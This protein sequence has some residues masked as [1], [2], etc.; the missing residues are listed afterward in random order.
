MNECYT[1]TDI[2]NEQEFNSLEWTHSYL[3]LLFKQLKTTYEILIENSKRK[4]SLESIQAF[5]L[6]FSIKFNL[7]QNNHNYNILSGKIEIHYQ[8][9]LFK[10]GYRYLY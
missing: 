5:D 1:K 2:Q 8:V 3:I 6:N 9:P 7:N 10:K 4:S